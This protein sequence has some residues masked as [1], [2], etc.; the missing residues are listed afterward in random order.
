MTN[1][2][3]APLLTVRI[4]TYNHAEYIEGCIQGVLMQQTDFDFEVLIGEDCSTDGTREIVLDY[5]RRYPDLIHVLS[6][7]T[8]V[9]GYENSKRLRE[10]AHGKYSAFCEGDD[11][12]TNPHKLQKQV[13][14]LEAHPDYAMCSHEVEIQYLDGVPEKNPFVSP[15]VDAGFEEVLRHGL[16]I[17]TP[18]LVHRTAALRPEPSWRKD[19]WAGHWPSI[20]LILLHGKNHHFMESMALKRKHAGGITQDPERQARLLNDKTENQIR[21][22][23]NLNEYSQGRHQ[24]GILTKIARLERRLAKQSWHK[25]RLIRSLNHGIR[26]LSASLR[27]NAKPQVGSTQTVN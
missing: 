5:A 13:D 10:N 3:H 25:K 21:F 27:S 24:S 17:P 22:Y 7:E 18:S 19:L 15:L 6:S 1:M 9:G 26:S 2:G 12:W 14:F 16:F 4:L 8:N 23:H 11:A 20:L